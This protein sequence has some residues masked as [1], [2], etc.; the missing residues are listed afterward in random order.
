MINFN[1]KI[2]DEVGEFLSK[3]PLVLIAVYVL[4]KTLL[5]P[6][7]LKNVETSE[8][9]ETSLKSKKSGGFSNTYP[10]KTQ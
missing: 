3:F 8:T 2:E 1:A 10:K 7:F 9:S 6:Y 4:I 5:E